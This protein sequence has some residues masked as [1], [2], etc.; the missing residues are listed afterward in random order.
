MPAGVGY[1]LS[2]LLSQRGGMAKPMPKEDARYDGG[3]SV[4]TPNAEG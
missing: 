3:Q 2:S 4:R 1:G